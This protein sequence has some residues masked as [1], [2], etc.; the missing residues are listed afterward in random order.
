M[1][2]VAAAIL[3]KDKLYQG[4]RHAEIMRQVW[5]DFGLEY[6]SQLEQGFITDTGIFVTRFQ[7]SQITFDSGQTT[8]IKDPLLS[9]HLW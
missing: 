8:E 2:I 4:K 6:I 1:R 9:E 7:A 5:E 3:H